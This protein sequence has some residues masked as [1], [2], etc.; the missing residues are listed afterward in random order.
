MI[1]HIKVFYIMGHLH[2]QK[3]ICKVFIIVAF[4]KQVYILI[5]CLQSMS[6]SYTRKYHDIGR[7]SDH[8]DV[9]RDKHM[10]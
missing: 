10:W 4:K 7:Y 3:L 2:P 9:M 6:K 1:T 5:Y 8:M